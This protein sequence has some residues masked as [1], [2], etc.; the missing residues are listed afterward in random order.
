MTLN[1]VASGICFGRLLHF[2]WRRNGDYLMKGARPDTSPWI[3]RIG[4][5]AASSALGLAVFYYG[6]Q[7]ALLAGAQ[8]LL[9]TW[10]ALSLATSYATGIRLPVTS[11]SAS[12][13]LFWLWLGISLWWTRVPVTSVINFWWMG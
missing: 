10:L 11:L 13:T 3:A 5:V 8:F 12:V 1:I 7:L 4:A 9:I 6:P 2:G